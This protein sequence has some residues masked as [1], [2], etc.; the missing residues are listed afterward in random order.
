MSSVFSNSQ[1]IS[2]ERGEDQLNLRSRG[3]IVL[4]GT[5]WSLIRKSPTDYS[6]WSDSVPNAY[7]ARQMKYVEERLELAW[8][9]AAMAAS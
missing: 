3:V 9:I 5:N 1:N 6:D 8:S 4:N 2:R 7:D